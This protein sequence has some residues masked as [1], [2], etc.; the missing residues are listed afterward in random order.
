MATENGGPTTLPGTSDMTGDTPISR[1]V[2]V[3]GGG[4]RVE[5]IASDAMLLD[6]L[7]VV[8]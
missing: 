8:R 2:M 7:V 5:E 6:H 3:S 1:I 4:W